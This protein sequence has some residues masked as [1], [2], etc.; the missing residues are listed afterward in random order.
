VAMSKVAHRNKGVKQQ[1]KREE[2]GVALERCVKCPCQVPVPSAR[3][4]VATPP[5]LTFVVGTV[6]LHCAVLHVHGGPQGQHDR[7]T[8]HQGMVVVKHGLC[9]GA[10]NGG[11][12]RWWC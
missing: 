10:L 1:Y 4:F 11:V 8:V 9:N 7:P 2:S 5:P 6:V 12:V 3:H